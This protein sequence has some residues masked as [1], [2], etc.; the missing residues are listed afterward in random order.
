MPFVTASLLLQLASIVSSRLRALPKRGESGRRRLD[1]YTLALTIVLAAFQALGIALALEGVRVWSPSRAR[2]SCLTTTLTLTGGVIF[3]VWL[4]GQ[5]TARGIG[6]GI[7]LIL[8][9]GIVAELPARSPACSSSAGAGC[10][11]P[12]SC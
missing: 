3:L 6:N 2:C 8:A 7:A 1:V 11:R 9:V 12:I 5:I 10:C 4:A